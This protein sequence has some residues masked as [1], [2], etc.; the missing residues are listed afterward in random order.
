META[1]PDV[2][3]VPHFLRWAYLLPKWSIIIT[4]LSFRVA[5]FCNAGSGVFIPRPTS[6]EVRSD[7]IPRCLQLLLISVSSHRLFS[8]GALRTALS[9]DLRWVTE[10]TKTWGCQM[11]ESKHKVWFS[12]IRSISSSPDAVMVVKQT[13]KI[14]SIRHREFSNQAGMSIIFSGGK[15]VEAWSMFELLTDEI[16]G[17]YGSEYEDDRPW[18]LPPYGLVEVYRR[19][20][21]ASPWRWRQS[22][23]FSAALVPCLRT[24]DASCSDWQVCSSQ[25]FLL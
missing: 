23:A 12:R 6:L 11:S 13:T 9:H 3:E 25:F 14:L 8:N 18:I 21:G 24:K 10:T 2:K 5:C 7:S 1:T 20:R 17:S 16:L 22:V 15:A 19:F 4:A